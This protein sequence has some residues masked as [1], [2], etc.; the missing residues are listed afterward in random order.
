MAN[1]S[2]ELNQIISIFKSLGDGN[3]L[4]AYR[5]LQE[6]E[7]CVCQ[8]V[9]MLKLAPST[10]SKHMSILKQ[11]GLV[12]SRK[13]GRWVHYRQAEVEHPSIQQMLDSLPTMLQEEDKVKEDIIAL[14]RIISI[15]PE[16]LCQLQQERINQEHGNESTADCSKEQPV[17]ERSRK[18]K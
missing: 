11:A 6:Q 1:H 8:I 4:R 15:D 9:E 2:I 13:I 14:S 10:V 12:K 7:L 5:A 3:R 18:Q 17:A 16:T